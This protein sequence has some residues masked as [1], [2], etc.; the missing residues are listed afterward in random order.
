M[1]ERRAWL[2]PQCA[3]FSTRTVDVD[4]PTHPCAVAGDDVALVEY[5]DSTQAE[6]LRYRINAR[7]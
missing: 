6:Q 2:C 1:N 4:A 7:R 5:V 3:Q